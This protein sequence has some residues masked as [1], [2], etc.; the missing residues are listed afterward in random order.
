MSAPSRTLWL[1]VAPPLAGF[2]WQLVREIGRAP[3]SGSDRWSRRVGV[4][5]VVLASGATFGH[6]LRL[7]REPAGTGA[8]VQS[9][10]AA[11]DF[12]PLALHLGLRLDPVSGAVSGLACAAAMAVAAWLAS[13]R[14]DER[15]GPAWAWLELSVAGGLLSFLADDFMTMLAGWTLAGAA[16]AW[17]E[18]WIDPRRGAVRATRCALAVLALLVGAASHADPRAPLALAPVAFLVAVAAMSAS[19]LPAGAPLSLAAVG[20][21]TTVGL[22]GPFLL[23]RL[24]AFAPM[25]SGAEPAVAIAG[26]VMLAMVGR[27]ALLAPRGP[28]RWL[29]LVSGVPAGLT[30]MSYS[31]DGEKGGLFVLLSAGLVAT[32]LL[33]VG[34]ARGLPVDR[35]VPR[36]RRDLEAALLGRAPE[37][38]GHLLLSFE[39][40]VIDAT[41]G[42]IVVLSYASAWA[43]SRI[44]GRRL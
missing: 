33:L 26:A 42:A 35:P 36:V 18:G 3:R 43:L 16:A 10:T 22:I 11:I 19:T 37:A 17:L 1:I 8:L 27:R 9:A 24:V 39:R 6:A 38:A 34:A 14:A 15:G 32:L 2:A 12:G 5:S 29:V 23:L 28:L 20:C 13:R 25:P 4:G 21:G 40:W 7:A 41:G 31:S 30:C 44:D